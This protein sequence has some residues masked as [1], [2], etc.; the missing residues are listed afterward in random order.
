MKKITFILI[1]LITGTTFAQ[2]NADATASAGVVTAIDI[3]QTADLY[4]G[5]FL[6]SGAGSITLDPSTAGAGDDITYGI[7]GGST[8][9]YATFNVLASEN[10]IFNVSTTASLDLDGPGTETLSISSFKYNPSGTGA[11]TAVGDE[12]EIEV[13]GVLDIVGGETEG[14]YTGTFNVAVSYE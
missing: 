1:A 4:F 13:G 6:D 2:E 9:H 10:V 3:Q 7:I 5:A 8:P 14:L 11:G 12:V